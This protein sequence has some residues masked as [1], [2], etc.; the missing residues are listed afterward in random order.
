VGDAVGA[1][2]GEQARSASGSSNEYLGQIILGSSAHSGYVFRS[3]PR[4]GGNSSIPLVT[5][6]EGQYL[7][8]VEVP[9][10]THSNTPQLCCADVLL[11]L[12]K[13]RLLPGIAICMGGNRAFLRGSFY[14]ICV[15]RN[16]PVAGCNRS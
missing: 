5:L 6:A 11:L 12:T 15:L 9:K 2:A 1:G 13:R 14:G 4:R 16:K 3:D 8:D 7:C 10:G